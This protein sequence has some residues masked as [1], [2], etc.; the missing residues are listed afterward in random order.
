MGPPGF[1]TTLWRRE[2]VGLSRL[3]AR[4]QVLVNAGRLATFPQACRDEGGRVGAR[5]MATPGRMRMAQDMKGDAFRQD[6]SARLLRLFQS[7]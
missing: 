5:L 3:L 6:D 7:A 4:V 1:R 2:E